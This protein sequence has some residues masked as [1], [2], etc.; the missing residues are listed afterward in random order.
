MAVIF[1]PPREADLL[2]WSLNADLI[3][4][5]EAAAYGVSAEQQAAFAVLVT[6]FQALYNECNQPGT[7]TPTKIEQKKIAKKALV[8]EA[9]KLIAIVQA[10]PGTT[11]DMR[12]DLDVTIRD[13]EPTPV[14]VP[15]SAPVVTVTSVEG[16][17]FNLELR[18]VGS[19]S[20][21]KPDGV[22]AAWIYTAFGDEQPTTFEVFQFRGEARKTDT[23][24][25]MPESVAPGTKVW[26][27]ACWVNTAG[28]PGPVS[29]P[30]ATWTTHGTMKNNAA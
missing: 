13:S 22:R 28:K 8:T 29:M 26:V 27:S 25:V 5:D 9:R 4:K 3:F 24:I 21:A 16:R 15:T 14:P 6:A 7:R 10:F 18:Q 23:Q 1:P 30:I 20:R 12:R 19:D 2:A 11:D 17:L